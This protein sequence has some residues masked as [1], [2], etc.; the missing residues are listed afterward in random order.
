[1]MSAAAQW[2]CDVTTAARNQLDCNMINRIDHGHEL[3]S[4]IFSSETNPNGS[5]VREE[6]PGEH[7]SKV[8]S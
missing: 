3:L 8:A 2:L 7:V 5:I 6:N 4:Q 1:M